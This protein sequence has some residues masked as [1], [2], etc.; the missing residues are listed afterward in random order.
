MASSSNLYCKLED[1]RS[2]LGVPE[3]NHDNDVSMELAIE[4]ASREI[5]DYCG[6][7]FYAQ[8]ATRYYQAQEATR[9][10]TD[11]IL[12]ITAIRSD[13][14]ADGVFESTWSTG[15]YFLTPFNATAEPQPQPY[16]AII[17]RQLS[18]AIF[19]T[20]VQ[21]GVQI[22]G[23]FGY[24]SAPPA[25]VKKACLFQAALGYRAKD[26]PLGVV[27]GRD[28]S[29]SVQPS[30]TPGLGLHPFARRMLDRY[31]RRIVA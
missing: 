25:V 22:V 12:A 10:L 9:L 23:S 11:D 4:V 6:R 15:S 31:R 8:S 3:D 20:H 19:P 26:A 30:N 7:W 13:G 5:D 29:Q 24:S 16:T 14:D 28:F 27:G 21:R 2:E 18:T 1:L 17:T